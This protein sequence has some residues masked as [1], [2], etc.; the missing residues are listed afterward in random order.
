MA[1]SGARSA[2]SGRRPRGRARDDA[3]LSRAAVTAIRAEL[4][5]IADDVVSQIIREV[6][7]YEAA[8]EGPMGETIRTAVQV[9]LGGFLSLVSDRRGPDALAPRAS[10]LD[11]A[12]QLGR[13]EAR[14][15]RPSDALLSA[16]RIGARTSWQHL[17]TQA[18]AH[19]IDP[20]TL[21]SFAELVFTYIDELS[22]ATV[23]GHRDE[24]AT[25][26]RV[27]Q[28]QLE[29][30]ARHLITGAPE[31]TVLASAERAEWTPPT[32]LT[33][34]ITPDSQVGSLLQSLRP[35]T[36]QAPDQP[37]LE[38]SVVVL[39]P[40]AH[41]RRRAALL[42]TVRERGGVV[43]PA[44]AWL[45][46]SASF[47]RALR[48][49][50]LGLAGDTEQHLARLILSADDEALADLRARV[51]AP[52]AELRES[53]AQKL[54]ETLRAWLLHQGR[55]DDVAAHLFVHPQTV[56]YRMTQVRE[57]FGEALDD[58]DTVLDLTLALGV[59]AA[60]GAPAGAADLGG[61]S[62]SEPGEGQ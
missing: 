19:G 49:R 16:Y 62:G 24:S 58:P 7:A 4:P 50:G 52:L 26:V 18:V 13:G 47:D 1:T 12:Y 31:A 28:R 34:V 48:V 60:D 21:A 27:R 45:E 2:G 29:R 8:F 10:A 55:R 46:A 39:V 17:S 30:L 9:A 51:L 25:E 53:S 56:R 20:A 14:S 54:R 23:A 6:P 44:R 40:D 61:G 22:G 57:L 32:T 35:G 41:G 59:E 15:G 43:G 3:L 42:R 33:A 36:L 11:G 5:A 37:D 38:G